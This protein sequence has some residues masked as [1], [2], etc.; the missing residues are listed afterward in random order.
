VR[1]L[2]KVSSLELKE[3]AD[4]AAG[5]AAAT[6]NAV[7]SDGSLV[8]VPLGDL[9]DLQKECA[10]L[11]AEADRLAGAIASQGSKLDPAVR[12]RRDLVVARAKSS[13]PGEGRPGLVEAQTIGMQ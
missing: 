4:S 1:R 12:Q 5:S 2:A 8:T 6:A 11:Q 3:E 9:V 7:L 10:R 13:R